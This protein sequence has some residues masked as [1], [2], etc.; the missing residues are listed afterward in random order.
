MPVIPRLLVVAATS[1]ELGP[2]GDWDTLVCGVG[3]VEAAAATAAAI[4]RMRPA[5]IVHVGIAGARRAAGIAP[6]TLVVGSESRYCDLAVPSSLAP[7]VV[8]SSPALVA[9]ARSALPSA[10]VMPIGT[11][12]RVGGTQGCDIEAME[13]F[14]VLRAAQLADVP[15]LEVRCISNEIEETDRTRWHFAAAFRAVI[16]ATPLIVAEV[17]QCVR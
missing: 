3:P 4:A 1:H 16:D 7:D 2:A 9:A 8:S 12:A 5:A 6:L 13:G 11:S 17:A 10:L 15:A 14:S